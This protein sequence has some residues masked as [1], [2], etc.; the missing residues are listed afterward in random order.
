MSELPARYEY[1]GGAWPSKLERAHVFSEV[2]DELQISV[3]GDLIGSVVCRGVDAATV[4]TV[5]IPFDGDPNV[6]WWPA[7]SRSDLVSALRLLWDTY[8]VLSQIAV[9]SRQEAV[10]P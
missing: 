5:Y 6:P 3:E 7:G 1:E 9:V 2:A 4:F 8:R 10:A